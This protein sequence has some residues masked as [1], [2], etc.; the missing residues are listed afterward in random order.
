M[1]DNTTYMDY[2]MTVQEQRH[3]EILQKKET[4]IRY[5]VKEQ[6]LKY[7]KK[8]EDMEPAENQED[9]EISPTLGVRD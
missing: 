2:L 3:Q 9:F 6:Y 4:D 5:S 8:E 1:H 7:F